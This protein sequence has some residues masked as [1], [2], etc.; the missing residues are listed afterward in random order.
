MG[1]VV[2]LLSL[3]SSVPAL[4]VVL[5]VYVLVPSSIGVPA[6]VLVR[7][8]LITLLKVASA[9]CCLPAQRC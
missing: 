3:T 5:P 4:I 7:L 9:P 8:P 6:P 2:V 1:P